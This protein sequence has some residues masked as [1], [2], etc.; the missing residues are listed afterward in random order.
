MVAQLNSSRTLSAAAA[1]AIAAAFATSA[2]AALTTYD[3]VGVA[4][5]TATPTSGN[6]N[7]AGNWNGGSVPPSAADTVLHFGGTATTAYTAT[8]NVTPVPFVL[9]GIRFDSTAATTV[10]GTQLS[11]VPGSGGEGAFITNNLPA[12]SR[13][14]NPPILINS[15]LTLQGNSSGNLSLTGVVSGA[16]GITKIGVMPVVMSADNTFAGPLTLNQGLT[17]LTGSGAVRSV[18]AINLNGAGSGTANL[19]GTLVVGNNSNAAA[20]PNR[21]SDTAPISIRGG[22]LNLIGQ[23]LVTTLGT[24]LVTEA[25]GPVNLQSGYSLLLLGQG[26][27]T[28]GTTITSSMLNRSQGATLA[29]RG[30]SLG[31]NA[32]AMTVG[33]QKIFFSSGIAGE[34]KGGGGAAGTPT[35]SIIPWAVAD[36][37]NGSQANPSF[38]AT[39]DASGLRATIAAEYVNYA[40]GLDTTTLDPASNVQSG[41]NFN[42]GTS[43][44]VTVNSLRVNGGNS[45]IARGGVPYTLN[46]TS[47]GVLLVTSG[48]GIG[49]TTPVNA[50]TLNF[51]AA[52]GVI[53]SLSTGSNSITSVLAGSNGL[54]KAGTG[55][56]ILGADNSYTGPTNVSGGTVQVGLGTFGSGATTTPLADLGLGDVIVA[57]GGT[58]GIRTGVV[59]AIGDL[60]TLTFHQDGVLFGR[61]H[62]DT[63]VNESVA[64][65]VLGS[66]VMPIGTYGSTVS[67][68]LFKNDSYFFGAGIITVLGIPEPSSLGLLALGGLSL[69]RRR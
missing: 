31:L 10:S 9:T 8:N 23:A 5:S 63:L 20:I 43:G 22:S 4:G 14:F 12:A 3:W 51:G 53:W 24:P 21:L 60:Q 7:V 18:S 25:I 35:V 32:T 30:G 16:G 49:G 55:A 46:V 57:S 44:D 36:S 61:A 47:G 48:N 17:S 52:E 40:T 29:A 19:G 69:R 64:S 1:I 41:S 54:T 13:N 50:G 67:P 62:L 26:S 58:L 27:N 45:P 59:N 15:P 34:V 11:F 65:L 66:T 37:L 38:F 68:A 6:W 28:A 56:L 39:Y 33:T 42:V 2:H